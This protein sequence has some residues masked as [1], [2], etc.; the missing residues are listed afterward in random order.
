M[1][2]LTNGSV[3]LSFNTGQDTATAKL[4]RS[5]NDGDWHQ[6]TVDIAGPQATLFTDKDICGAAC[7]SVTVSTTSDASS[8]FSGLPYFG[9]VRKLVPQIKQELVTDGSFVGCI[10]VLIASGTLRNNQ[11]E[12]LLNLHFVFTAELVRVHRLHSFFFQDFLYNNLDA[13]LQ[14][15]FSQSHLVSNGCQRQDVCSNHECKNGGACVDEW[16]QYSCRCPRGFVGSFCEHQITATF[17]SDDNSGLKFAA[18][19]ITSFSLEFS[20]DPSLPSGVLVFTR[21]CLLYRN[22]N[23]SSLF[24][25]AISE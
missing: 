12:I 19:N 23:Q 18:A 11:L 16:S 2:E 22:D 1:L 9:G 7:T 8:Q 10:K 25:Q 4:G 6:I 15:V 3:R 14:G 24:E 21:V 13:G 17:D 5:L 20:I